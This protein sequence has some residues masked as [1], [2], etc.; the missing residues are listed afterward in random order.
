M[1]HL[2]FVHLNHLD[3]TLAAKTIIRAQTS[4]SSQTPPL[5]PRAVCC[6]TFAN[7]L[8]TFFGKFSNKKLF[9]KLKNEVFECL[10]LFRVFMCA[11]AIHKKLRNHS[12]QTHE[13]NRKIHHTQSFSYLF[14]MIIFLEPT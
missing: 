9:E 13:K 14:I 3:L 6:S 4:P 1:S 10:C 12:R 2:Q 8:A 7:R 5:R 11:F